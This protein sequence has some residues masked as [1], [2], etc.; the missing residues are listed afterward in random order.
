MP[1]H[2]HLTERTRRPAD[3]FRKIPIVGTNGSCDQRSD[4]AQF[5]HVNFMQGQEQRLP[6][7]KRK[8]C[9]EAHLLSAPSLRSGAPC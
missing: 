4:L 5:Y 6:S 3:G 1:R 2:I 8:V 7:I 9:R